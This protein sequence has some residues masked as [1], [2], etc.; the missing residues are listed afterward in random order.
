MKEN[1]RQFAMRNCKFLFALLAMLLSVSA[2][3][4]QIAIRGVVKDAS[5]EPIIGASVL[6]KGTTNGTITDFDGNFTLKTQSDGTLVVSYVGYQ[7]QEVKINGKTSINITLKEDTE[8]LDE[9]VVI[10]YGSVKRKDVTTAISSVST[11]D[12]DQRFCCSGSS[13]KGSRCFGNA[14]ERTAGWR[15]VNSCTWYYFF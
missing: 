6:E 11:K 10:G 8:L 12:L 1:R 2:F 9:V 15:N 5:D 7:T 3:A 14:T 13:R 4:Q